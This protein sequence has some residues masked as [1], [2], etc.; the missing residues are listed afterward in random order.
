DPEGDEKT[1][2]FTARDEHADLAVQ[3]FIDEFKEIGVEVPEGAIQKITGSL[4]DPQEAVR[5]FKNEKYPNI[6][7]TVDL[8]TTGIDV[9]AICNLVFLRRT[10][11]RILY[12]QMLGRATRLCDDIKKEVFRIYDAVR[13]YEALQDYSQ[14]KPVVSQPKA[15]FQ[16]LAGEMGQIQSETRTA[17]QVNQ[18]IA[19]IQRKKRYVK[20]EET[21]KF[22]FNAEGHDPESFIDLLKELPPKESA[23]KIMSLTQLWKY[24]D[25]LKPPPEYQL[26]SDHEDQIMEVERGYGN[27]KR[28]EDYLE[29]FQQYIRENRNKIEALNLI[30]TRPASLDRASLKSLLLQLD[31]EGFTSHKL[32]TAWK[33]TK[34]E[35]IAADII[36]YI[37]T[38]TLGSSLI[39]HEERVK[40]AVDRVRNLRQWNKVQT[41]WIDRFEKQLL[42]E[43]IIQRE[44]LDQAPFRREGGFQRLNKVF[45]N[46]L[47]VVIEMINENLYDEMG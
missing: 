41:R 27:F 40:K 1:L 32:N 44:D 3:I 22:A 34:N 35:T 29:G 26:Y 14:M 8:L 2:V 46:Q 28:P 5:R 15:S 7:V 23:E 19:K 30:F 9:P 37:R 20:G 36:S 13:I 11:S 43:F 21:E 38:L 24:L 45:D 4:K 33:D 6:V 12:E 47:D 39:S 17:A 42:K 10:R 25:E 18:I 16:Q 31:Q